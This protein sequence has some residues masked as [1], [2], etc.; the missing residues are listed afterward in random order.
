MG[1]CQR[2]Q[3]VGRHDQAATAGKLTHLNGQDQQLIT[4][5][6]KGAGSC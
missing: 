1:G 6:S 4:I 3:W 5:N 2:S